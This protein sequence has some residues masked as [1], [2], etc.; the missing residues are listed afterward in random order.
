MET[1]T[2]VGVTLGPNRLAIK[3]ENACDYKHTWKERK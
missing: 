1:K 2:R 3:K